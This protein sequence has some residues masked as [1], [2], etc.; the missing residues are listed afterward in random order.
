MMTDRKGG[1]VSPST[2][3]IESLA[4]A[5]GVDM[6]ELGYELYEY[7]DP[8]ALDRLIEGSGSDCRVEFIVADHS[9]VVDGDGTVQINEILYE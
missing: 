3:V 8:E 2:K 9:V 5:E 4:A 1:E 6:T 7:I